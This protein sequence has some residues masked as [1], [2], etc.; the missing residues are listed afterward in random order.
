[1][2][3]D[4]KTAAKEIENH[5]LLNPDFEPL[6][7]D[8]PESVDAVAKLTNPQGDQ[9]RPAFSEAFVEAMRRAEDYSGFFSQDEIEPEHL[10]LGITDQAASGAVTVLDELSANLIFLRRQIICLMAREAFANSSCGSL[11]SSIVNGLT[12]LVE[13]YQ[14]NVQALTDLGNRAGHKRLHLPS[15]SEIVHMV[16]ITYL[17]DFSP[18]KCR[19]S[20]ICWKRISAA[21]VKESANSTRSSLPQS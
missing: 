11:R 9:S 13:K 8:R 1:M 5:L 4:T 21:S 10:L 15:R 7:V 17:S 19:S 16:V 14:R 2:S 18:I 6:Y 12:E 20:D 3:I